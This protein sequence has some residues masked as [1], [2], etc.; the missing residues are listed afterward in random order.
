MEKKNI[1]LY[2]V[3]VSL[4]FSFPACTD[5]DEEVYDKISADDFGSTETEVASLVGTV[6]K[7][8]KLYVEDGNFI[9]LEEECGTS[10]I[11]PTRSGGDWY[12]SGIYR[13]MYMHVW[14]SET[15]CIKNAWSNASESI[16]TCNANLESVSAS[17][18]ISDDTKSEYE[19]EI[20]GVRAFWYYKMLDLWGNIPL[21][22]D[23]SDKTLPSCSTRQEVFDWLIEEVQDIAEDCPEATTDNYGKFTVGAAYALLAKLCLNAEAWGVTYSGN[24]YE[25]AISYCDKVMDLGYS[26][27]ST[28]EENFSND[29]EGTTEAILAVPFSESDTDKD[30]YLQLMNRTLHY[31]DSQALGG[32]WSAWNGVCAQPDYVHLFENEDGT[33]D[34]RKEATYLI[35][36][37][38]DISTGEPI[39]TDHGYLLDHTIDYEMIDGTGY[40]GT[41]WGDVQQ[42]V[43]ARCYKWPFET[44]VTDAMGN[45][46][47]IF[48]LADIILMKA[49]AL[50][51]NGGS[52]SEATSLV[53]EIRE[54]AY[55]DSDHNYS[56]VGLDEILLERRLELAWEFMNRQDD[57]RFDQFEE[58]MWPD[59][60]CERATGDYLKLFPISQDAWQ[61]NPNLTQNDGYSSFD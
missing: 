46:F 43:G 53:N 26:L 32:S 30:Y 36:Q 54:R 27:C 40:D 28:F 45:D 31:K 48:R 24:A 5:L 3:G 19:A 20:R 55:G 44:S 11:T 51:R 1:L 14:T 35:G 13:E 39:Y 10:N 58:G 4:L 18:V 61:S 33:E 60:N 17:E 23:Y 25:D 9:A 37:M 42:H 57:I 2:G 21:V 29:N 38:Y 22:T 7:T 12:D 8:L 52:T 49:E 16:G 59:S 34:P 50:I 56:T 41:N 47:Y 6:R 15:S